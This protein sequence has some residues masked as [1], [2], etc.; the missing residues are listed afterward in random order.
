VIRHATQETQDPGGFP[1]QPGCFLGAEQDNGQHDEDD[2]F[3]RAD[4]QQQWHHSLSLPGDRAGRSALERQPDPRGHRRF[5]GGRRL[6]AA[7]RYG[8]LAP[9]EFLTCFQREID[10]FADGAEQAD[11]IT[12][13]ASRFNGVTGGPDSAEPEWY[14]HVQ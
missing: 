11:D 5:S 12:M 10:L 6:E 13:L 8:D 1:G 2:E 3:P 9:E 4:V 7:N 14:D